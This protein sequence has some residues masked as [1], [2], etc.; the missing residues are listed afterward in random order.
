[1]SD[2]LKELKEDADKNFAEKAVGEKKG[3]ARI[4]A[5][6]EDVI[7]RLVEKKKPQKVQVPVYLELEALSDLDRW[8]AKAT[9][10][11]RKSNVTARGISRAG[12]IEAI[13]L[14][15]LEENK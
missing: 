15:F 4:G 13:L 12:A 5:T 2:L 8:I 6:A 1:M 10:K 11:A 9:E 3:K 14:Q 7:S